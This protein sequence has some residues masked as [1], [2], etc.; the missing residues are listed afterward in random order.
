M[1]EQKDSF[2]NHLRLG[3][4]HTVAHETPEEWA[5]FLADHG[6]RAASFPADYTAPVHLIDAYV[7][8][9]AARHPDRRGR[10][11]DLPL[12]HGSSGG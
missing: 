9:A 11:L 6:F 10:R 8:E 4:N 3:M 12:E 2:L 1:S 7:K 5:S